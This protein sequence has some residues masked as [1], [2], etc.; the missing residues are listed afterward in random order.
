MCII[1]CAQYILWLAKSTTYKRVHYMVMVVG[2]GSSYIP[3]NIYS[4]KYCGA[5][6]A[7]G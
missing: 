5:A 7:R 3:L 4:P 6:P 2:G 1:N